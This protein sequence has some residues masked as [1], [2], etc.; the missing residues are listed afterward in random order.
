MRAAKYIFN[1]IAVPHHCPEISIL[2]YLCSMN[3]LL[4]DR[5]THIVINKEDLSD[6]YKLIHS[7]CRSRIENRTNALGSWTAVLEGIQR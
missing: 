6:A 1:C 2:H 3:K 7:Y 4:S 5:Q